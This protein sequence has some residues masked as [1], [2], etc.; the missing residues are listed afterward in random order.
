[1]KLRPVPPRGRRRRAVALMAAG[2]LVGAGAVSGCS[3]QAD[4][5]DRTIAAAFYPLAYVAQRVAGDLAD[6]ENLTKPGGE[7]HDLELNFKE[8]AEVSRADLVI[9]EVGFQPAVDEAVDQNATGT[10]LDVSTVADLQ[11]FGHDGHDHA[12]ESGL[13]PHFWQD[14]LRLAAV[15]DAVAEDLAQVDP[16]HADDYRANAADLRT[17]LEELDTAY[18]DGLS[19]CARSTIV[20]SHDAFGYLAKY[21]LELEPIAGLSPG[22]EPT[23]A[24]LARLQSLI[25]ADGITTVFSETLASPKMSE[26]LADDLGISTAVLDPIEGLSDATSGEDYLSIMRSNLRALQKANAC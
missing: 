26:T 15:G 14:P 19:G 18:A 12:D 8:V 11:P 20:V 25:T 13:D 23:A 9:H 16:D 24:D 21:G 22:A 3:A 6:V 2:C 1:M 7:P 10:V 4:D 17:D 5:G